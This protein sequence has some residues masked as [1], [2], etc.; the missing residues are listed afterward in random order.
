VALAA[1]VFLLLAEPVTMLA[2][3]AGAHAAIS[4]QQA[5]PDLRAYL[6]P[7]RAAAVE[8]GASAQYTTLFVLADGGEAPEAVLA[9]PASAGVFA[10]GIGV[11]PYGAYGPPGAELETGVHPIPA[12]YLHQGVNRI[13]V[14]AP[15]A[16]SLD[17]P[18]AFALGPRQVLVTN[19]STLRSRVAGVR[20]TL[21]FLALSAALLCAAA[22]LAQSA[23][24]AFAPA[25]L[26]SL[27]ISLALAPNGTLSLFM[28]QALH[29]AARAAALVFAIAA[30]VLGVVAAMPGLRT[31]V[32]HTLAAG[33]IAAALALG[34]WI[35]VAPSVL[36]ALIGALALLAAGTATWRRAG[37][38]LQVAPLVVACFGAALLLI[39]SVADARHGLAPL[40]AHAAGLSALLGALALWVMPAGEA[41]L[42]RLVDAASVFARQGQI[43]EGQRH[44]L[45][46]QA[47]TLELAIRRRAVLE[48]R[49]RFSRDI[50]DGLGGNLLALLVQVRAEQ[51]APAA[52]AEELEH[53]LDELR[54]MIDS[55]DHAERSLSAALSTFH[56]RVSQQ[57][58]SAGVQL[59]WRLPESDL[60]ECRRPELI[61]N[62]YRI[63]QEAAANIMRH[64]HASVASFVF[65][66]DDAHGLLRITIRDNGV[67][68]D[69]ARLKPRGGVKN[70]ADR[71]EAVGGSLE[72]D[73]SGERGWEL[74]I[75]LP[76]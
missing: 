33:V 3:R 74:R 29:D 2:A 25:G 24:P 32:R 38:E 26:A 48:E 65:S 14:V 35:A 57:F 71:V 59:E 16:L 67:G 7:A 47:S 12:H 30:L 28:T 44:L 60:P 41:L 37:R 75:C 66:W 68:G 9:Y 21:A 51:I 63:L 39:A 19:F 70:M 55:L 17:L 22:A 43:I 42:G 6:G 72:I 36:G 58:A 20:V 76:V 27:F 64:A 69:Y 15:R 18:P 61:L 45:A 50:H 8:I 31:R 5:P 56:T 54:L 62:V 1:G 53:N 11:A 40:L 13:D 73:T 34:V 10:N 4:V 49:E 52:V 46:E 23:F